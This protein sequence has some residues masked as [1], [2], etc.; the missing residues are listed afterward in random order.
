MNRTKCMKCNPSWEANSLSAIRQFSA[1]YTV[2]KFTAVLARTCHWTL[3]W[4]TWKISYTCSIF[5]LRSILIWFSHLWLSVWNDLF[6]SGVPSE[7]CIHVSSLSR[8]L[9]NRPSF[10]CSDNIRWSVG[11]RSTGL[12]VMRFCSV[13]C[14][15]PSLV[16]YSFRFWHGTKMS[17]RNAHICFTVLFVRPIHVTTREPLSGWLWNFDNGE[18]CCFVWV[19]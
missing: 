12:W 19:R 16:M 17:S 3:S 5:L 15:L 6:L 2:R 14:Y 10:C 9:H 18:L 4:T 11:L 13:C 1:F 8:V 7:F